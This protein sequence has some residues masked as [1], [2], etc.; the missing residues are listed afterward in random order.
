MADS[1]TAMVTA[2]AAI[3]VALLSLG[4]TWWQSRQ[5]KG[6]AQ[7]QGRLER[8]LE[9]LK[10]QRI[11]ENEA[12]RAR[13]DYEYEARKRLYAE[14]YPLVFQ[15]HEAAIAACNRVKNL[16]RATRQGH[17]SPGP[18]NWLDTGDPYYLHSTM[19]TLLAP[20]AV[21]E[22]MTRRLT[23]FDLNLDP[24]LH[25]QRFFAKRA[26]QCLRSDFDLS[27]P[28][29]YPPLLLEPSRPERRYGP[30]ETA[31][32]VALTPA[33]ERWAW[34]QGLYSGQVAQAADALLTSDQ[35]AAAGDTGRQ[36]VLTYAEF[37]RALGAQDLRAPGEETTD[38]AQALRPMVEVLR[39]FHPA[40]RPV[41]WR[42]LIAQACC[43]RAIL[44][45]AV[46]G[47]SE[48]ELTIK[49]SISSDEDRLA[50]SWMDAASEAVS[51]LA[52]DVGTLS[53]EVET[54][55]E[56]GNTHLAQAAEEFRRDYPPSAERAAGASI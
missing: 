25:R 52:I 28:E 11:A 22:L 5:A 39:H 34:R 19:Y 33:E 37:A 1:D 35:K 13:R 2:G 55:F 4:G 32:G 47:A 14:L 45:G 21:H 16:A 12:A 49:A 46:D 24:H 50:Y 44:A 38:I 23:L 15:L 10:S 3:A 54:A 7:E 18:E 56:T 29:S 40:R 6:A 31:P 43:Y 27:D 41:T 36:R 20:L 26:Y 8:E 48:E 42:I 17:L 9:L 53:S 30:P 51:D